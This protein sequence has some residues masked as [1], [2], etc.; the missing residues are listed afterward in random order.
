MK[1]LRIKT[2]LLLL[3][4]LPAVVIGILS[5]WLLINLL[6]T[7]TNLET[8]QN[9]I[10]EAQALSDLIQP[11]QAERGLS[12][13]FVASKGEKN[14]DKLPNQRKTV[15]EAMNKLKNTLE[16]TNGDKTMLEVLKALNEKRSAVD[17]LSITA[18]ETGAYYTKTILSLIDFVVLIPAQMD[19]TKNRNALQ[20]YTH[21]A[22]AKESLGQIRANLNGAFTNN[23]FAGDTYPKFMMS[24]GAYKVNTNKFIALS[25][26]EMVSLYKNKYENANI[27]TET[28]KMVDTAT[29]VATSGEFGIEP[30]IWF[31][32][33]S[34]SINILR[35]IETEF[36]QST[37]ESISHK[38]AKVN[39]TISIVLTILIIACI[40]FNILIYRIIKDIVGSIGTLKNGLLSFFAFLNHDTTSTDM[41]VI[42]S[43]D[44]FGEIANTINTNIEKINLGLI[45]DNAAVEDAL[46]VVEQV[47]LGF[48][49]AKITTQANNP[50]LI[51]LGNALNSMVIEIKSNIDEISKVLTQFSQYNFTLKINPK[52]IQG[53]IAELIKNVNFLTDEISTLLR[54]SLEIG[55]TL[56]VSSDNLINN[57]DILSRSSNE[58]AAS[59]EET[60]AALEEI[61]STIVNNANTVAQMGTYSNQVS[62]SAT[63]GQKLASSTTQAMDEITNEVNAINEAISIIDQIAFQTNILSLNAA[64]EAATAGEA[65]KGFAVVAGEVRNLAS[66][67][68]EAAKEIKILVENATK[69]ANHGKSISTQMIKGYGELLENI[70]KTTQMISDIATASREQERGITQINDAVTALDRQ[71][72][73]NANIASQT[74]DIAN[75]TDKIAK[76]IVED[77]N[78]KEFIGKRN[79]KL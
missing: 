50:Q 18:P 48:L 36:Y 68:A 56:E 23:T 38:L 37:N 41:I 49:T 2:K 35:E 15:D 71:T 78:T 7:K 72:Q 5:I 10:Q 29:K 58:A 4:I 59:L 19:D 47:K 53:D 13:G 60:A 31:K 45:Q 44:E 17:N 51:A 64:V 20:A 27:V 22:T 39:M 12:V 16:K 43:K 76:E 62:I 65:G 21:F 63:N 66:R 40:A 3:A 74:Q 25:T 52:N 70:N 75:Q 34:D 79:I 57:V 28:F 32:S 33:V 69:K 54:K 55:M 30:S 6:D 73:Q 26:P 77:A 61:T 24:L 8:T 67:S 46:K 9:R 11:L 42:I 14:S 1:N